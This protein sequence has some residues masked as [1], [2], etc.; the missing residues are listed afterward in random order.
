ERPP[1]E[2]GVITVS[3]EQQTTWVRNFNPFLQGTRWPTTAGIHE[4]LMVWSATQ[5]RYVP[6]LATAA[7]WDGPRTLRA[8]LRHGVLW[9]DGR[10]FGPRDVTFTCDLV[11][12][13]PGL[14]QRGVW[15]F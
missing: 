8:T 1:R 7:T 10:P 15:T 6:W 13:A 11:R 5:G 14:D 9:S 2:P 3:A 4:P 12:R